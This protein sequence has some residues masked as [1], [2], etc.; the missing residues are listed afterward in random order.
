MLGPKAVGVDASN[1]KGGDA[2]AAVT[3]SIFGRV[4]C[5]QVIGMLELRDADGY[6]GDVL[7]GK[8]APEVCDR[9]CQRSVQLRVHIQAFRR[10]RSGA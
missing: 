8:L 5:Y 3:V 7:D 9:R 10:L 2:D 4:V 1:Q 6:F